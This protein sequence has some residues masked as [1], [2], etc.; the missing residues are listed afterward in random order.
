[1]NQLRDAAAVE[2]QQ[3]VKERCKLEGWSLRGYSFCTACQ[4]ITEDIGDV[5]R[6]CCW[7][8]SPRIDALCHPAGSGRG[9]QGN[10][11]KNL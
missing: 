5:E 8:G 10:E 3:R 1:M 9:S 7:C 11:P 2:A 6:R 4:K